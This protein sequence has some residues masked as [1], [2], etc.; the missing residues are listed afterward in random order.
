MRERGIAGVT[1]RRRRS[2]PRPDKQ[3]GSAPD[4]LGR[5]FTAARPGTRLVGDITYLPS[6]DGRLYLASWLDLAT[7]EVVG[8][9]MAGHH[10]A[11]LEV[12]AL[13]TAHGR[14]GLEPGCILHSDRGSEYT[15]AESPGEISTSGLRRNTGRTGSCFDDN[16]TESFWAVLKEEIGTRIRPDRATACS[17]MFAFIE[18]FYNRRGLRKHAVFGW[19][20]PQETRKRF[21]NR[22]NT[23]SVREECPASRGNFPSP[24]PLPLDT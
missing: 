5:D 23:R 3:A 4:L 12:D 7:R 19:L 8:Y 6:P 14:G 9:A 1:R 13:R 15:S 18:T 20:T 24:Q 11:A 16:A 2:L 21:Q 17:D 22:P 10:H